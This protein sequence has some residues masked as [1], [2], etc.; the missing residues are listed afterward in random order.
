MLLKTQK[1]FIPKNAQTSQAIVSVFKQICI[2]L[3]GKKIKVKIH[4]SSPF[5][6]EIYNDQ[7]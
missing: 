2:I 6:Y 1:K 5:N 4:I 7:I 3:K